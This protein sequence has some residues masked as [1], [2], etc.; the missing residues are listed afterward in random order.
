MLSR[1]R[2]GGGVWGEDL[3]KVA[4]SPNA[5][6]EATGQGMQGTQETQSTKIGMVRTGD[7]KLQRFTQKGY[8][9]CGY[10]NP[11][12]LLDRLQ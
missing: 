11:G 2:C 5:E 7:V 3:Y 10:D 1:L 12:V 8:K 9:K 4:G 6:R